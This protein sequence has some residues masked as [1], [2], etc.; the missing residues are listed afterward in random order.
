VENGRI[1]SDAVMSSKYKAKPTTIGGVK[2]D[3]KAE[4]QRYTTLVLLEKA[5]KISGLALQPKFTLLEK[6][7]YHGKG[8]RAIHY[9]A[10][11][12][13]LE[14]GKSI[15][16]DV[17]GMKTSVYELKLKL[18]LSMYGDKYVFREIHNEKVFEL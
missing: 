9:V 3:S 17:K 10:D 8:M 1:R 13:Y 18:F 12:M 11:F 16:E 15:V 2:F 6:F 5:G 14:N 7:R 4:A